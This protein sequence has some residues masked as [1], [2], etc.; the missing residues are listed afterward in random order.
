MDNIGNEDPTTM[1]ATLHQDRGLQTWSDEKKKDFAATFEARVLEARFIL[2]ATAEKIEEVAMRRKFI[3]QR[4]HAQIN[5]ALPFERHVATPNMRMPGDWERGKGADDQRAVLSLCRDVSV[6]AT[7]ADQRAQAVI[8]ALPP[9]NQAV[10]LIDKVTAAK[11]VERDKLQAEAQVLAEELDEAPT[12]IAL[13]EVDQA[14]T[15]AAFRKMVSDAKEARDAKI[16]KLKKVAEKGVELEQAIS[17]ALY[18]GLPGLSEAVGEQVLFGDSDAA[19]KILATF[20]HDEVKVNDEMT[21]KVAEAMAKLRAGQPKAKG[22]PKKLP[23]K[24]GKRS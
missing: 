24:K 10:Q 11:I 8:S 21:A 12:K 2:T 19:M 17:K 18:V 3:S 1:L 7:I 9:L 20:E 13:S 23:A 22:S 16:R 6:L 14:M 5:R 15:I 4:H